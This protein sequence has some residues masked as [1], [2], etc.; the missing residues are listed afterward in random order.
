MP[1]AWINRQQ[2]PLPPDVTPPTF[3]IRDLEELRSIL[4]V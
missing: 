4:G 3:E 2:D 1:V